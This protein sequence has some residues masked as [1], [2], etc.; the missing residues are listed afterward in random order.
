MHSEQQPA[1][2]ASIV[3]ELIFLF[4]FTSSLWCPVFF[5]FSIVINIYDAKS[6]YL[7]RVR[8]CITYKWMWYDFESEM[9]ER[10]SRIL[11]LFI[12]IP[13]E[14]IQQ[15]RIIDVMGYDVFEANIFLSKVL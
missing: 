11:W 14:K 10:L 5:S 15:M 4:L 8:I 9:E 7:A 1:A 3:E 6:T 12:I 2:A 13:D